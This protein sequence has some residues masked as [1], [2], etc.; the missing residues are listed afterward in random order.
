[1]IPSTILNVFYWWV[2]FQPTGFQLTVFRIDWKKKWRKRT[3]IWS[4]SGEWVLM[5]GVLYILEVG[6]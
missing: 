5:W 1:M 2:L 4:N 3:W 6:D